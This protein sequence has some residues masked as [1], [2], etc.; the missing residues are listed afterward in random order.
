VGALVLSITFLDRIAPNPDPSS[1]P[2]LIVSWGLLLLS[3]FSTLSAMLISQRAFD[4]HLG[5][6]DAAF[7]ETRP[8][9][10]PVA[11]VRRARWLFAAG[12]LLLGAG[13]ASL[14]V[15]AFINV[16]FSN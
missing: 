7:K 1:R 6:F 11:R 5:E 4:D 10:M 15:F 8:F 12:T 9:Q 3:L 2:F 13:V 16:P 14:A